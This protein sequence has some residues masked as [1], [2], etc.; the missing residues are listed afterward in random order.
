MELQQSLASISSTIS[1]NISYLIDVPIKMGDLELFLAGGKAQA[2]IAVTT[3]ASNWYSVGP[4]SPTQQTIWGSFMITGV[5]S[6]YAMEFKGNFIL[7]GLDTSRSKICHSY[8]APDPANC[9]ATTSTYPGD[10]PQASKTSNCRQKSYVDEDGYPTYSYLNSNYDPRTRAW[11]TT[12]KAYGKPIFSPIYLFA[13]SG[14]L[15]VTYT[16]PY[17]NSSHSLVGILAFDYNLDSIELVLQAVT[18]PNIVEYIIVS[19]TFQL[20][21]TS[22]GEQKSNT[23]GTVTKTATTASNSVIRESSNYI[24]S[25]N[26]ATKPGFYTYNGSD[27]TV[28]LFQL[29]IYTD[30][31]TTIQWSIIV[32]ANPTYAA[33]D[34]P[35]NPQVISTSIGADLSSIT[36][37]AIFPATYL[38]FFTGKAG[39]LPLSTPI[40]QNKTTVTKIGMTQQTLW[41]TLKSYFNTTDVFIT[42]ANNAFLKYGSTNYYY[43][44]AGVN[45][46]CTGYSI[47]QYGIPSSTVTYSSTFSPNTSTFYTYAKTTSNWTQ[48][49]ADQSISA[50]PVIAYSVPNFEI[51]NNLDSIV[52]ATVPLSKFTSIMNQYNGRADIVYV[53]TSL[54]YL[55]ATSEGE[56]CWNSGTKQLIKAISSINPL[57]VDSATYLVNNFINYNNQFTINNSTGQPITIYQ[58]SWSDRTGKLF[59]KIIVVNY[60]TTLPATCP[61][62]QTTTTF[63]DQYK[64]QAR[65]ATGAAISL[66]ILLLIAIIVVVVLLSSGFAIGKMKSSNT[67]TATPEVNSSVTVSPMVPAVT[68]P[69]VDMEMSTV[70]TENKE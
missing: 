45:Q 10:V 27:G 18:E 44:P 57:I 24:N 15:G 40:I 7:E 23:A 19:S 64:T 14:V 17:Y 66:G 54:N 48:F 55:V 13:T 36:N 25:T 42:Y 6:Y 56:N 35:T 31:T 12:C 65:S 2:P 67:N 47:N 51:S 43:R 60:G 70:A 53:M 5:N 38:N 59:W 21:A 46:V 22:V 32:V 39:D 30:P 63:N 11:Y 1:T 9:S 68:A 3:I 20:I 26:I 61:S 33:T 29:S 28:F 49:F 69:S 34:F 37:N 41:G 8:R 58:T 4:I 52:S 62:A 50:Q 16:V